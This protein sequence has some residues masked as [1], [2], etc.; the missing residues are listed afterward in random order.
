MNILVVTP[1]NDNVTFDNA[2]WRFHGNGNLEI[3]DDQEVV[4]LFAENSWSFVQKIHPLPPVELQ[5]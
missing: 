3:F 1:F 4:A 2:N 5:S